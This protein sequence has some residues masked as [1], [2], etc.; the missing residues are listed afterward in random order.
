MV[1]EA[2]AP[3]ENSKFTTYVW[4]LRL[5]NRARHSNEAKIKTY[6]VVADIVVRFIYTATIRAMLECVCY[7]LYVRNPV[8]KGT[9]RPMGHTL[10]HSIEIYYKKPLV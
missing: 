1:N 6:L 3:L 7:I 8:D 10:S 4:Q 5:G 9:Y 2:V